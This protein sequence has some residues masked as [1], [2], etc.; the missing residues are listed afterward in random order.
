[1]ELSASPN[2]ASAGNTITL[3]VTLSDTATVD[4]PVSTGWIDPNMFTTG[5]RFSNWPSTIMVYAG[6]STGYATATIDSTSNT[7]TAHITV[8]ANGGST[9]CNVVI[10]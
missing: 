9:S 6:E 10:Q 4:T 1:V 5:V 7:G 2:P 8:S 3:A